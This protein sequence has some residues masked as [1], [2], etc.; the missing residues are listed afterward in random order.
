MCPHLQNT[1]TDFFIAIIGVLGTLLGTVLG[2]ILNNIS[3]KGKLQ[4]YVL[5]WK[6]SFLKDIGGVSADSCKKEDVDY[7]AY[8]CSIDVYNSS[9]E[10]KIMRNIEVVFANNDTELWC[11]RTND[12]DSK[13]YIVGI[14]QYNELELINIPPKTA[15]KLSVQNSRRDRDNGELDFLWESNKI[16]IRYTNEKNK[17]KTIKIK[18]GK[19]EDYLIKYDI[20]EENYA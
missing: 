1:N 15:M 14:P 13:Y 8:E 3:R 9:S 18:H 7:Y 2:W 4:F 16:F 5:S 10:T 20:E 6:D 19:L 11:E 12:Y 17:T